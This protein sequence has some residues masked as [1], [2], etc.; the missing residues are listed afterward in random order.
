MRK[1][2]E[3]N[4]KLVIDAISEYGPQSQTELCKIT[5]KG[6]DTIRKCG[7]LLIKRGILVRI[8]KFGKYQF[9]DNINPKLLKEGERNRGFRYRALND[10]F[11][12]KVN[13]KIPNKFTSIEIPDRELFNDDDL[14]NEVTLYQFS[15][16][17][18]AYIMYVLIKALEPDKWTPTV[19]DFRF[20]DIKMKEEDRKLLIE[21]WL[22]D[23]IDAKFIFKQFCNLGFVHRGLK[24]SFQK[25]E[26]L[27]NIEKRIRTSIVK[28][29]SK[30]D[31][32]RYKQDMIFCNEINQKAFKLADEEY[33]YY[34]EKSKLRPKGLSDYEMDE[35]N[36]YKLVSAIKNVYPSIFRE[37]EN[38]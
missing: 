38:R 1:D 10:I 32:E 37:L 20:K 5:K 12:W 17:I 7:N 36:Y 3:D 2:A 28:S 29:L 18:A 15:N 30:S 33:V 35:I 23:T 26:P 19:N 27:E 13:H 8:G 11:K 31:Q 6:P 21:K 24:Q 25:L 14:F 9:A 34:Q 4:V 22:T 16:K